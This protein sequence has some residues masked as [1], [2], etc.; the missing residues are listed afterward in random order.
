MLPIKTGLDSDFLFE[1]S[2]TITNQVRNLLGNI[3]SIIC[4]SNRTNQSFFNLV[5]SWLID[6]AIQISNKKQWQ[7]RNTAILLCIDLLRISLFVNPIYL[8]SE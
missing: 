1:Q 6:E 8:H 2:N 5:S 4:D 3:V 7:Q